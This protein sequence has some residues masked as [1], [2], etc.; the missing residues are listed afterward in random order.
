ML[1]WI[2]LVAFI[3]FTLAVIIGT[4]RDWDLLLEVS[5][6]FMAIFTVIVGISIAFIGY[7]YLSA[8]A[9]IAKYQKRY[10]S[11][12][13]QYEN[14]FYDNDNDVG[15]Y[16][17]MRQIERWNSDLAYKKELQ[18]DFWLGIYYP[19]IYDQFEFIELDGEE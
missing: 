5:V 11:L 12:Y 13:Y 7:N 9:N 19:N 16:E 3:L 10:E 14:N 8:N 17:L 15:K 6:T 2:C 4:E 1:F 18:R